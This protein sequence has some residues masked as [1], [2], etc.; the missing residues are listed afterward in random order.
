LSTRLIKPAALEQSSDSDRR[1][2]IASVPYALSTARSVALRIIDAPPQRIAAGG[3][4]GD[5]GADLRRAAGL[6]C[7]GLGAGEHRMGVNIIRDGAAGLLAVGVVEL[8]VDAE[9]DSALAVF[10]GGLG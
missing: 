9:I 7:G 1:S 6:G 5:R 10:G 4:Q 3:P 8:P 2:T